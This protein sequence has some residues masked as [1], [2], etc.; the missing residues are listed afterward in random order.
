MSIIMSTA[1]RG[2]SL[3][4]IQGRW[5]KKIA[6]RLSVALLVLC[7]LALLYI[8]NDMLLDDLDEQYYRGLLHL[9]TIKPLP[10]WTQPF[11][12]ERFLAYQKG[13][14][15]RIDQA[16]QQNITDNPGYECHMPFFPGEYG[17]EIAAMIPWAYDLSQ[18]CHVVTKGVEGT[19]Y[20]YFFS[21]RHEIIPGIKREYMPLPDGNPF[22][23][24]T[25]HRNDAIFPTSHW[26]MPP[27]RQQYKRDDIHWDKPLLM[28]FNKYTTEWE[29]PPVNFIPVD[30]L[31]ELLVY[32]VPR[33]HVFYFRLQHKKLV[34]I[35]VKA[36]LTLGDKEMIRQ[37]FPSVVVAEDLMQGL[38]PDSINL[39]IHSL[40]A[41]SKHFISVQGGNSALASLFGGQ[42]IV[43][44]KA[45]RELPEEAGDYTYY[46][47]F[48]NAKISLVR[49]ETQLLDKVKQDY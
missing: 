25:H 23:N 27:W 26:K 45:G 39:L 19:K 46:Y 15:E 33:Y 41:S 17:Y 35:Q 12:G 47:R 42:N 2:R 40:G 29:G 7:T 18:S 21:K 22:H 44:A 16:R 48:S 11:R 13:I 4:T 20:M 24:P 5:R 9:A 43:M 32:L 37:E 49:N 36:Y 3:A 1:H 38:D 30:T 10:E 14:D 28:M 34:D 8:E 31:R 6:T